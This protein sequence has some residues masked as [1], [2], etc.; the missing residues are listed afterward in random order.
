MSQQPQ[1]QPQ[2]NGLTKILRV[3][4]LFMMLLTII[5]VPIA[6][7][8]LGQL[9]AM[10]LSY[11][12]LQSGFTQSALY[13]ITYNITHVSSYHDLALFSQGYSVSMA[14]TDT[15][16]IEVF[17]LVFGLFIAVVMAKYLYEWYEELN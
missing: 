12:D 1:P 13:Q 7:Y 8:L 14:N 15:I 2:K 9:L 17:S 10:H 16:A 5:G 4:V 6:F 11:G 3:L